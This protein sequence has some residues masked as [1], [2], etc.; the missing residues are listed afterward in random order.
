M[1]ENTGSSKKRKAL[2]ATLTVAMAATMLLSGTLAYFYQSSATNTIKN[3]SKNVIGHDDFVQVSKTDGVVKYD[4]DVYVE[5]LGGTPVLVRVKLSEK[6]TLNGKPVTID[7]DGKAASVVHIPASGA[8]AGIGTKDNDTAADANNIHHYFTWDIGSV[9]QVGVTRSYYLSAGAAAY[10]DQTTDS[11]PTP[12]VYLDEKNVAHDDSQT[13]YASAYQGAKPLKV[14]SVIT[15]TEYLSDTYGAGDDDT[16]R[17]TYKGWVIDDSEG[18]NGWAYWSQ[19][20][21]PGD[22]TG[23]LLNGVTVDAELVNAGYQ[24][25]IDVDFE[26]VDREDEGLW[27]NT[28][29]TN[30]KDSSGVTYTGDQINEAS[31]G[32]KRLMG[33]ATSAAP[34]AQ[35]QETASN[36]IDAKNNA[37]SEG[38]QTVYDQALKDLNSALD[39]E[40]EFAQERMNAYT[41]MAEDLENK[42]AT[43]DPVLSKTV[44]KLTRDE[45]TGAVT[46][47]AADCELP[48]MDLALAKYLVTNYG[49]GDD[50][51]TG[52]EAL[53]VTEVSIIGGDVR[54]LD[55]L[56][57]KGYF[58]NLMT[59]YMERTAIR[60]I[61]WD[62]LDGINSLSLIKMWSMTENADLSKCSSKLRRLTLGMIGTKD[63]QCS[64]TGLE[65]IKD[66]EQLAL[67]AGNGTNLFGGTGTETYD[68]SLG[69]LKILFKNNPDLEY[70]SLW[71]VDIK[72][73]SSAGSADVNFDVSKVPFYYLENLRKLNLGEN[74]YGEINL[75]HNSK[76]ESLTL[77]KWGNTSGEY[78]R[79]NLKYNLSL[80]EVIINTA[81]AA[82][83]YVVNA[84]YGL[85]PYSPPDGAPEVQDPLDLDKDTNEFVVPD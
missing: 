75:R 37:E 54:S 2:S 3:A 65:S 34:S 8:T 11:D 59:L 4:K 67:G 16:G 61:D 42:K 46:G 43:N 55:G 57:R 27:T 21:Q 31:T 64:Y 79:A 1:S 73:G 19:W 47:L 85:W 69:D 29:R 62:S 15:M 14:G 39:P 18:G 36:L 84:P 23:I 77:N 63:Y 32:A 30:L 45:S 12:G 38:A 10:S 76:L 35:V 80:K 49:G 52:E 24:Y 7:A 22:T 40:S 82:N 28:D 51:L 33:I 56:S 74:A 26:A 78:L 44:L 58:G 60:Q 71:L 50:V 9:N 83:D 25:D 81:I 20:L 5:N 66:L 13:V 17:K 72:Q 6:F 48:S 41:A 53:T 70:L 68:V